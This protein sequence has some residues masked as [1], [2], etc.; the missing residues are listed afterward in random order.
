[1]TKPFFV[2]RIDFIRS[3]ERSRSATNSGAVKSTAGR[4]I[5][6]ST[7]CGMLVGPGC[8]KNC[9]PRAV[10]MGVLSSMNAIL[11]DRPPT[12]DLSRAPPLLIIIAVPIIRF[13]V[14]LDIVEHKLRAVDLVP[15]RVRGIR[16]LGGPIVG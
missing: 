12:S 8:M 4:A 6:C 1:M 5:A 2:L 11:R 13:A 3:S 15:I 9:Q 14:E 7:R 10:L 16:A